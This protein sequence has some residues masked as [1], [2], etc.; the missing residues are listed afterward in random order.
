MISSEALSAAIDRAHD[1]G[2]FAGKHGGRMTL[3]ELVGCRW[4]RGEIPTHEFAILEGGEINVSRERIE[5]AP[6][7]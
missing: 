2:N 3:P 1:T 6:A 4:S 5:N 7:T